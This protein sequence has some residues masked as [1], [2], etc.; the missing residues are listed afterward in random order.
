MVTVFMIGSRHEKVAPYICVVDSQNVIEKEKNKGSIPREAQVY[1]SDS[2]WT[3][4]ENHLRFCIRLLRNR[5]GKKRIIS[6]SH[7][8]TISRE[9]KVVYGENDSNIQKKIQ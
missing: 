3:N 5:V 7:S 1:H 6:D 4:I 9:G 2:G 8:T